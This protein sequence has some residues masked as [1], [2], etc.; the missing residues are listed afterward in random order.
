MISV[1]RMDKDKETQSEA[2]D[3]AGILRRG[4]LKGAAGL[5]LAAGVA[6]S[7]AEG[8]VAPGTAYAASD[9]AKNISVPLPTTTAPEQLHLQWG[10]DPARSVTVSWLAPGTVAQPAPKLAYSR[11]PITARNPGK[12]VRLPEPEPLDL[13][14]PRPEAAA[15]SFTDGLSG[16]TTYH[17]HVQLQDLEPD[18]TYYYEVSDGAASPSVAGASFTTAPTGRARFRFSSFGD[19]GEPTSGS[20]INVSGYTWQESNDTC[21]FT[22]DAVEDPGDGLGAPLFHLLNGDLCYGNL[23][24]GSTPSVWRDF[25]VNVARSAANRPWMPAIG[26]HENEFGICDHAGHP[27]QGPVSAAGAAGSYYNGPYGNGHYHSRFLLPDNHVRNHDGN[28]LQGAFYKFQVGTVLF[29]SV[30]ADDVIY[31]QSNN[32]KTG[33]GDTFATGAVIPA[34][35]L[36]DNLQYTGTLAFEASDNSLVPDGR[37]AN[38]QAI[39]L[40]QT[41][42][43]ARRDPSVDMIVVYMHQVAMSTALNGNGSD[44]GIRQA[45]APLFDRYEVDLV[46]SGHEHNYERSYPVRGYDKPSGTVTTAFGS[47][48][49]G[50]TFDTRRP[51][52]QT[53]EPAEINGIPAWNTRQG[54]VYLVL[55]GGGAASTL[56]YQ[57]DPANGLPQA[58]VW[59]THNGRDAVEDAPWSAGRDPGDAYGYA[60][61]DV[62]PGH[63]PGE[64]TIT[65]KWFQVP[66]AT[67]GGT[68]TLPT[69]PYETHI[70]GRKVPLGQPV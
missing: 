46:L 7:V 63:R 44:M 22:V 8:I 33:A 51:T 54:T 20:D 37:T 30:D 21:V 50:D 43:E 19:V 3:S 31:Q 59:V 32:A 11:E 42:A 12:V 67:S 65:F 38:V 56:P 49:V 39:W 13:R 62:D 70:F 24:P 26:N 34:G 2:T 69:A 10:A 66:G 14:R 6:G 9:P 47:Y 29:V 68:V 16:E 4:F 5:G 40:E 64:T 18:T 57:T 48:A 23:D 1:R 35:V 52:V 25:G 27:Y 36:G 60:I 28:R 58:N 61:F 53:T 15:T 17:Y 45:W 41:L 55:G